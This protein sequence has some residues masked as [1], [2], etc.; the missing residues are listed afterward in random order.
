MNKPPQEEKSTGHIYDGIE[1]LD[2]PVPKWFQAMFFATVLFGI[3]YFL[4]YSLGEGE[5][6]DQEYH[7]IIHAERLAQ[8]ERVAKTG[9][10][11]VPSGEEFQAFL[12]DAEKT[13]LGAVTYQAKCISC[14]GSQGQGG[15]GPNL[16]DEYWLHGGSMS[17]IY[18]TIA[19]GVAD[20]GMPPWAL[21]V[22]HEEVIALTV[23]VKSL[24][25][26]HPPN[27]KAPQGEK[28]SN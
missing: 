7:R 15:I 25:G 23:Y 24:A 18:G 17:Q 10:P 11:K 21:M 26:T 13:K 6:I 14:H 5:S 9:G 22:T 12:K 19:N 2:H 28:V 8:F 1:E 27:A 16:T 20:K 3:A 4:Y